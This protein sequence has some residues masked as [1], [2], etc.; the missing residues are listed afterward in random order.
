M[1]KLSTYILIFAW[2]FPFFLTLNYFVIL[3]NAPPAIQQA[4]YSIG[5]SIQFTLPILWVGIVCKER[6]WLRPI[7]RR[8]LFEGTLFGIAVFVLMLAVY[9]FWLRVP[10]GVL[11]PGSP[12][13][14]EILDKIKGLG[15]ANKG[16]F[17]LLG[18]FYAILHSGLEEYYWRWFVCQKL[19]CSA[20]CA[21]L[22][23]TAHHVILLGTFFGY[24][25][26]Y[27][28]LG[29]LGVFVG[30]WYWGWLYR[31]TDSVW[32]AWIGHGFID[33]AI[34]TIGFLIMMSAG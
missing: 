21:S 16:V 8:G 32:G 2:A 25:S 22:G 29:S 5:K 10:G 13:C 4:A 17:V 12:A 11:A 26:L 33:A 14:E 31:R 27:C 30:G 19:S 1:K 6:C 9:F 20:L 24:G 3:A 23:F 28:W 18:V 7:N 15:L 34:F